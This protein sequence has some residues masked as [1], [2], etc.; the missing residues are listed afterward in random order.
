M[1]PN[2]E[3]ESSVGVRRELNKMNIM[4]FGAVYAMLLFVFRVM[5]DIQ[6]KRTFGLCVSFKCIQIQ[7]AARI[8]KTSN[9]GKESDV[10]FLFEMVQHSLEI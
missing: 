3:K 1:K 6:V 2:G 9:C 4:R 8:H 5:G 7:N 10:F